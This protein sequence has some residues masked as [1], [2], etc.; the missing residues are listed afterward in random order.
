[1]VTILKFCFNETVERANILTCR[2]IQGNS[3]LM[4]G[5]SNEIQRWKDRG[6]KRNLVHGRKE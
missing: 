3:G 5:H 4:S 6:S 2:E 1:M